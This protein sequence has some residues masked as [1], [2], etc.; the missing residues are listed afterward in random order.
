MITLSGI[1]RQCF[2]KELRVGD[3]AVISAEI[4]AENRE[5]QL[6]AGQYWKL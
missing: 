3:I 1:T 2:L 5:M 6:T 4:M